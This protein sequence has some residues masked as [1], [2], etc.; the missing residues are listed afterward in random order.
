MNL[1]SL[2]KSKKKALKSLLKNLPEKPGVY[3]MKNINSE[4]IYIG[5]SKCIKK[6][7]IS[8]FSAQRKDLK[9]KALISNIFDIEFIVTATE[10][11]ALILENNLIKKFKPRY[12]VLL[13]DS[14]TH[15]YIRITLS[16]EIPR[17]EKVR[18][19]CYNDGNVYFGPFPDEKGLNKI[20][21]LLART[22]GIC[23]RKKPL[24]QY[25]P[26][27]IMKKKDY[28]CLRSELGLCC[29][30]CYG[31]ISL[32]DYRKIIQKAVNILSGK[33]QLDLDSLRS[34]MHDLAQ[35][36]QY[37]EAAEIR[38]TI[39]SLESFFTFQKVELLDPI[40]ID[41]WGFAEKLNTIIF[42]VFFTR[43]GKLLGHRVIQIEPEPNTDVLSMLGKVMIQ[44]YET[45][46]IPQKILVSNLPENNDIIENLLFRKS[47]KQVS[48]L[49]PNSNEELNLI[50]M[51][52]ENAEEILENIISKNLLKQNEAYNEAIIELQ[53]FL[54]LKSPPKRIECIDISHL[55]GTDTVASLVVALN[56]VPQKS[57]YRLYK[58]KEINKIDDPA[59]IAEV[60]KRRINRIIKD[61]WPIPDL[62]IVDGGITQ[63]RAAEREIRSSSLDI[64]VFGLSKSK[65]IL[66]TSQ[67]TEILLPI[68]SK[69][70]KLIVKLRDEAHR[71]A[72]YYRQKLHSKK[73]TSY[74][75]LS[76]PGVGPKTI[77]KILD[78]YKSF[79]NLKNVSPQ[80]LSNEIKIS[81]K[82]AEIIKNSLNNRLPYAKENI[83][84]NNVSE[85]NNNINK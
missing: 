79:E 49:T 21:E 54:N 72:N 78:R 26:D 65:E 53:K 16:E 2:I 50:K 5:K 1:E 10:L 82:V 23:Q 64:P 55:Q 30:I 48:I 81:I 38:D 13:K 80:E 19:V 83:E 46:I 6:R 44:F 74:G 69:S 25:N 33:E 39:L 56:G 58:I 63:V 85:N 52:N 47:N 70:L 42:T 61:N 3:L 12:N 35:N 17:I 4:I 27:K 14:K 57:E 43:S 7:V 67:N 68:S 84:S 60:V 45:N 36:F 59:C 15:P 9:T 73:I 66:V 22:L 18:K 77:Q 51:A 40:D 31:K 8:Y 20:I 76:L 75:L 28:C 37:E 11:E 32:E 62:M 71:F 29:G 41:I 24:K 34:K